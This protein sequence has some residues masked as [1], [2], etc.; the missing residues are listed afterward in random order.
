MATLLDIVLIA[1]STS[2]VL[3]L[4]WRGVRRF[5]H[6]PLGRLVDAA[7]R[8]R[9]G[10]HVRRVEKPDSQS[11]IA[12]VDDAIHSMAAVLER[13]EHELYQAKERAGGAAVSITRIF[14][15]M[16]DGV[17]TI[18][19]NWRVTYINERARQLFAERG[20]V[21]GTEFWESFKA[22]IAADLANLVRKAMST[23]RQYF[24][25]IYCPLNSKWYEINAF[26]SG[27]GLAVLFR[28]V[29][30]HRQA[31]EARRQMEQQLHQVRKMEA[32]GQLTGGVAHDFNNLLMIIAGNLEVIEEQAV[33]HE[34]VRRLAATSRKAADRGMAVIGQLLAFS[35]RQ[36]LNPRPVQ[37]S[38]L[39]KDFE[40]L[41][42]RALG[43]KCE[44]RISADEQLWPCDVDPAQLQTALLNLTVNGRDAMPD[45]GVLEIAARNDN[46]VEHA[47]GVEPGAYV[48]ISVTDT[49]CGM[50]PE[51]L[52][53]AFD[54]FFTTKDVGRGTGLGLSMVYGF[55]RQSHGH[56]TIKS[57]PGS[58]STISLYLPRSCQRLDANE[59]VVRVQKASEHSGRVLLVD[60]DDDVAEVTSA[61]LSKLGYRVVC[62]RS[63]VE[64]IHILKSDKKFD[65]LLTD[66]FMPQGVNGI[67]LAREARRT[68][69]GIKVLLASGN[70][71]DV[72]ATYGIGNEFPIIG[73]PF[74]R[75]ELAQHLQSV[76]R[77][78]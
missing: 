11:E 5:L 30:E 65:L 66:V 12:G 42:R 26:P 49:G 24:V 25:D 47:I 20:D 3:F 73:K 27:E 56:V 40:E 28:D 22:V 74:A 15:S 54:P 1:V 21:V 55:V 4:A 60:D 75:S 37:V 68:C 2:L 17:L 7:N 41:I 16:I 52:D 77:A 64:A 46:L 29:N 38:H 39:I 23:Q 34:S 72:L 10:D 18:D 58:G 6:E 67:E 8:L 71:T 13:R 44:L 48:K 51:V 69:R 45:G 62:A 31:V 78:A 36:E 9:L 76:M 43:E 35:R 59:P 50:T 14:E 61:M 32:V 19:R 70:A 63:G 53:R 33:D 57:A